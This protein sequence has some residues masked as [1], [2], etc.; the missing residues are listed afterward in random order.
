[1]QLVY[2]KSD[3]CPVKQ[4]LSFEA[5]PPEVEGVYVSIL[6][7]RPMSAKRLPSAVK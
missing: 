7:G 3:E 5:D 6:S 4:T 2:S 1:M